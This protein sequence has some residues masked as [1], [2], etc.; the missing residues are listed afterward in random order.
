MQQM[1]QEAKE[2]EQRAY[3]AKLQASRE[4]MAAVM[5]GNTA[6]AAQKR[7]AEQVEAEQERRILQYQ[8]QRDLRE[9]VRRPP[10]PCSAIAKGSKPALSSLSS[11]YYIG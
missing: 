2:A 8:L 3:A 5:E 9:Q 1:A 4:L 11:M 7:V 6:L 10:S